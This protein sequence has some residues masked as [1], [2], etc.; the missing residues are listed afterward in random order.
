MS[1]NRPF[2]PNDHNAKDTL[3]YLAK[4]D[5]DER[6][7]VIEAEAAGKA[8]ST[9]MGFKAADAEKQ[10]EAPTQDEQGAA[11][12]PTTPASEEAAPAVTEKPTEAP[13]GAEGTV[14][15][16]APNEQFNGVRAGV[17][18]TKGSA[19]VAKGHPHLVWFKENGYCIGG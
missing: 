6:K 13:K 18:F 1:E 8:R 7:R 10:G 4:A 3:E 15:I 14:T 19:T 9:V 5:A 11:P 16:K 17:Q 12:T 2:D